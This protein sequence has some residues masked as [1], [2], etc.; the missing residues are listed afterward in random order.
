MAAGQGDHYRLLG[1]GRDASVS[2]IKRAYYTAARRFHPDKNLMPGE[3][4]L[5]MEVQRAYEVLSDP[6]R[7]AQYDATLPDEQPGLEPLVYA[8]SY[9]RDNLIPLG[10]SQLVYGLLE[11]EPSSTAAE[12]A[13]MPLNLCLALDRSTSMM[14]E[15]MEVAKAAAIRLVRMLRPQ[16]LFSLV[17]FGDR[18][19]VLLSSGL[20][21]DSNQ[22]QSRIQAIRPGGATE[23]YRGLEA[24]MGE[25]R[26]G[27]E[28][29]RGSHLI[30][31]T[32]GHTY[33]DEPACLKLADEAARLNISISGFGVGSDWNDVFL[34]EL[35]GRTG[36]N[37]AY[38]SNAQDIE[39]SLVEKFRMISRILIDSVTL[40]AQTTP[41]VTL[42][43]AFRTQPAG[44]PIELQER[45]QLG[46]V[47]QDLPLRVLFEFSI[48][49]SAAQNSEVTLLEGTL[50]AEVRNRPTAWSP[51]NVRM[52]LP[53]DSTAAEQ[54]PPASLMGALSTLALYRLQERARR[55][56]KAGEYEAA[57]RHLRN[58][59]ARLEAQGE[60]GLS[61]TA[62]LEAQSIEHKKVLS[63]KGGKEIKY[64]TR[65]LL[66]PPPEPAL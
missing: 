29:S 1:V 28:P 26:R 49:A 5:F 52:E 6:E 45:L 32:D 9:S 27:L 66:L 4:E 14:G 35:V 50:N 20:R 21:R 46:A 8:V 12:A 25:L 19:E 59:A 53:V 54:P 7:R 62:M 51:M 44:G 2:A 61:K 47:V 42:T 63:E 38:I 40:E 39:R 33:G 11:A 65:A 56:A 60:H 30:V 24:A 64:G 43:Y 3:T 23:I 36:G 37:S 10:E 18:A 15:K 41:G 31:L 48:E 34:D 58:L 57:T 13:D 22:T 17:V 55:E 16:D